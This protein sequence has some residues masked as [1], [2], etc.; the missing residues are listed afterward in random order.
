MKIPNP[1]RWFQRRFIWV[2]A[3]KHIPKDTIVV[4]TVYNN[5]IT[6]WQTPD[7]ARERTTYYKRGARFV[8]L[9]QDDVDQ[10][11]PVPSRS[12]I[13]GE[14]ERYEYEDR[15]AERAELAPNGA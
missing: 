11:I 4:L 5:R 12:I 2:R 10:F 13:E 6:G 15:E 14:M 3:P 1:W 8:C 7:S 9:S